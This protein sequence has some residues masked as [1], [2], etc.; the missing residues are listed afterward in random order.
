MVQ[1]DNGGG[2]SHPCPPLDCFK[3]WHLDHTWYPHRFNEL[4]TKGGMGSPHWNV[5]MVNGH[6]WKLLWVSCPGHAG[7]KGNDRGDSLAGNAKPPQVVCFS[8]DLKCWEAWD[9]THGHKAKGITPLTPQRERRGKRKHCMIF[10]ERMRKGN[11]QSDK[12]WN[13]FKGNFGET[14]ERQDG[15]FQVHRYHLELNTHAHTHTHTVHL[16]THTHTQCIATPSMRNKKYHPAPN[17]DHYHIGCLWSN[18]CFTTCVAYQ[19]ALAPNGKRILAELTKENHWLGG[20]LCQH[21][22]ILSADI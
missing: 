20:R 9:T 4:A 18:I 14:S 19:W 21:G 17:E 12:Q 22:R 8:E 2:S 11:C 16:H 15:L 10:L 6:L 3:R 1:L 13:C 7:V 5:S